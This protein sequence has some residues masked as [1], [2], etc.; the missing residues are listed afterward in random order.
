[1]SQ[2]ITSTNRS[3]RAGSPSAP[4]KVLFPLTAVCF[5]AAAL[6]CGCGSS[7]AREVS[8]RVLQA[9][10]LNSVTGT[11]KGS[12]G[13]PLGET[14][15]VTVGERIHS[16]IDG[17]LALSLLPGTLLQLAPNS[18]LTIEQLKVTKEGNTTERT[19]SRRVRVRLLEGAIVVIVDFDPPSAGWCIDTP[20]GEL[21]TASAGLCRLEV[22]AENTRLTS[23]RGEFAFRARNESPENLVAA[24]YVHEWPSHRMASF[25]ADSDAQSQRDV[26]ESLSVERILLKLEARERFIPYPWRQL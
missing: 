3:V 2:K 1:M 26:H 20:H 24:G 7:V 5:V 22:T 12:S 18:T 4:G 19:M 13:R 25:P 11:K 9:E 6:L 21:S 16:G 17:R 8:A 23:V 14:S 10:G 15:R